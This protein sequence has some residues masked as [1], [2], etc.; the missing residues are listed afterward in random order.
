MLL[1]NLLDQLVKTMNIIFAYLPDGSRLPIF[2]GVDTDAIF[3]S[4]IQ[5]VRLLA[6]IFPF[7]TT[8]MMAAGVYLSWRV[9]MLGLKVALGSRVPSMK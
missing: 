8:M 3:Y 4:G 1:Y 6:R 9:I 5:Y 2:G 7:L